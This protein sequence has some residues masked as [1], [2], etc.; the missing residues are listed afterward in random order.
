M[1]AG[2]LFDGPLDRRAVE[3]YLREP[4]NHVWLAYRAGQPVGF[5][6]GT[7]L[8]QVEQQRKQFFLYEIAV[9]ESHRRSGVGR[10]LIRAMLGHVRKRGLAEAF[11]FTS[12]TNRAAVRLYTSTG[13]R[14]ETDA[15][16]MYV[17]ADLEPSRRRRTTRG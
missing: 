6:R 8:L 4:A 7:E 11:V 14:T 17:Y 5:L 13:G 12:P 1:E 16:R 3:R 15:D 9:S 2:R 10:A